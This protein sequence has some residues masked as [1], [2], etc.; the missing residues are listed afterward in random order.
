M[1]DNNDQSWFWSGEQ[2]EWVDI[3]TS[4]ITDNDPLKDKPRGFTIYVRGDVCMPIGSKTI[5]RVYIGSRS[6]RIVAN[7]I[8][9]ARKFEELRSG[10]K[11]FSQEVHRMV[12]LRCN[13]GKA[14]LNYKKCLICSLVENPSYLCKYQCNVVK[15]KTDVSGAFGTSGTS[16]VAKK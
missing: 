2:N 9:A 4:W 11:L 10:W 3:I 1:S 6:G 8:L 14:C 15:V 13:L 12:L 16:D 5:I 7:I